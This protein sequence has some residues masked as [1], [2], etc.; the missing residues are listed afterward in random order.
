MKLPNIQF[1]KIIWNK[2]RRVELKGLSG[3][4]FWKTFEVGEIRIRMVDYSPGFESD[5]WCEKGHILLV[6][7]GE[8]I[9]NMKNGDQHTLGKG[10]GFTVGDDLL[11]PHLACSDKGAKVFIVD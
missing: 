9:I 11:N 4:S 3:S 6:L 5:H 7:E 8:L 1:E 10:E 2:I